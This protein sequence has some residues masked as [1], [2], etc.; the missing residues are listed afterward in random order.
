MLS[1]I[2]QKA[3]GSTVLDYLE[4][5]LFAPLGIQKPTWETSP[6]GVSAGGYGLRLRTEDIAR[7]G[8]L[9]LQKGMW[10]GHQLLPAAWVEAATSLQ[11]AN[12]GDS[13][14]WWDQGYGYQ[15]WRT[16][17]TAYRGD[18]AFGQ[19]CIVLPDQDA[20]VVITSGVKNMG[21]VMDVV[22][23]KLVPALKPAAL[24]E[25]PAAAARL[26]SRLGALKLWTVPG[27][28]TSPR[29]GSVSGRWYTF[30]ANDRGI[31]ALSVDLRGAQPALLV[32]THRGEHRLPFGYGNWVRGRTTFAN[33]LERMQSVW[34]ESLVAGTAAW[35]A[36]DVLTV[37]LSLYETPYYT[38][39]Q[40]RFDGNRKL[41]VDSEHNV[42]FGSTKL[43]QLVGEATP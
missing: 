37:K 20:V 35:T 8:Q 34:A 33:G 43:P 28:R 42:G 11:T 25:D 26:R 27:S 1:A 4:P 22:F 23:D 32:R 40:L 16:R 2:V 31:D 41:V 13:L 3:T 12:G 9:L 5:R 7:F 10:N 39:L 29:A 14:G 36:S 15:F 30:P 18:G 38:T 17:G 19:F 21:A 24:P 6:Q